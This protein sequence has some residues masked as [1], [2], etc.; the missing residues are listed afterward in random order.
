MKFEPELQIQARDID[1]TSEITYSIIA[2]NTNNLFSIEPR[3]GKI[4]V[5]DINGL[6]MTN[7]TTNNI[8][9]T[10]EVIIL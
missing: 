9:L 8:V 3:S 6:D 4:I 7:V 2:G 5:A 1:K 10:I